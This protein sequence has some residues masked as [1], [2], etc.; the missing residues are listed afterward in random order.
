MPTPLSATKPPLG[1]EDTDSPEFCAHPAITN[2]SL[3][4]VV[5]LLVAGAVPLPVLQAESTSCGELVAAPL[6]S[7]SS[8]ATLALLASVIVTKVG[9]ATAF[10]AY[11][12]SLSVSALG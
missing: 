5:R 4:V 8:A 2:S 1:P 10:G 11:Q 12:T 6:H 7:E 9:P 3:L